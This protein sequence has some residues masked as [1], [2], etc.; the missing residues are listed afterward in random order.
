MNE[1]V[2][3]HK[4][5]NSGRP[6]RRAARRI[7]STRSSRSAH[8]FGGKPKGNEAEPVP[9]CPIVASLVEIQPI[10]RRGGFGFTI[11]YIPLTSPSGIGRIS[12]PLIFA[13]LSGLFLDGVISITISPA[14]FG[15]MPVKSLTRAFRVRPA[16][17][18]ISNSFRTVLSLIVTSSFRI[19]LEPSNI[20]S[21]WRR[22]R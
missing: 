5:K 20:S 8:P 18:T 7:A 10:L 17:C 1:A 16:A 22:T 6:I 9:R 15:D 3:T 2:M 19:P 12:I 11:H 13:F 21:K 4:E 14:A